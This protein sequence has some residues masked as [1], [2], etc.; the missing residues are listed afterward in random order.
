MCKIDCGANF[1][2][3]C[4]SFFGLQQVVIDYKLKRQCFSSFFGRYADV[5]PKDCHFPVFSAA[6]LDF[7]P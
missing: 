1:A 7:R 2:G 3:F 5:V 6:I 4:D